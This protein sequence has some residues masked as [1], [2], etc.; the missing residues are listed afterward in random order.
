MQQLKTFLT[1]DPTSIQA[2]QIF[3]AP[4]RVAK[5]NCKYSKT[6]NDN[7]IITFDT[8]TTSLYYQGQKC[9]FVYIAMICINGH[10]Y[11]MRDLS[12]LKMFLDK[13]DSGKTL[14]VIYVHNLAFDFSF[15][16]NVIPFENVF[17][18]RAHRVI[19]ARYKSWEFRC[20]YFLSQM[21]LRNVAESYKLPSAKLVDGLDYGKIRHTQTLLT[22]TE[23][24][25]CEMD[26][27]VLYEYIRYMLKQ[28]KKYREIPYTQTGF[29]RK[30]TLE[31]LKTNGAYYRFRGR[32]KNTMPNQHVFEMLEKC[33]AGGYTH[34]N[35]MAVATG[36][37]THVR[38]YDFTS[39]YPAVMAR[40]K[41]PI[42]QFR[43]IIRNPK[44]YIDSDSYCCIGKFLLL[45]VEPRTDLAYLS[46]HKCLKTKNAVIDNGRVIRAKQII[47]CLT[48]VDIKTVKMMYDCKIIPL[49]LYAATAD[50]LPREFVLSILNLYENKTTY[51]G[52]QEQYPLYMA[53]K[54]M[55]NSEYG[56]CAFNPFT[57]GV[58]FVENEWVPVVPT[59]E[60][61]QK[62]YNNRKTVLPYAWGVFV[63][64]WAR[65][66]LCNI[67]SK[68]GNDVLYMD[69]DSIK[70][71][72]KNGQWDGLFEQDNKLIHRENL[73][74]AER[75]RIP[76][77]KFA[78]VD[79][80][81]IQHEI[82]LWDFEYEYKSFKCLGAK[83][84]CYTLYAADAIKKGDN[85]NEIYPVVAG[86]P[87]D[88][89][90]TWLK[91]HDCNALLDPFRLD[92]HLDKCDSGKSTVTY[93]PYRDITIPVR[94]YMGNV[95]PEFI[96]YG[97]HIEPATFDMSLH[98]DYLQFLCGYAVDDKQ[99]LTRN[100]VVI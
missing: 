86:C 87:T 20:S 47:I 33:F 97:A 27:I 45:D 98:D 40:C 85:P 30:Y 53:S 14:N 63:T 92:I 99:E 29:V 21:S 52:I 24:K 7:N 72:N 66:K 19:F 55:V 75:L 68:I 83:R 89:I 77:E 96:G 74:A 81:G 9:S 39:S 38:S 17:A 54:Q 65:N 62:Y 23:L 93:H 82:G 3:H 100:G 79:K 58:D 26:I 18:R 41:F 2:E 94:D 88:A 42:G 50:Y 16:I 59:W 1:L 49:E 43:R 37:H 12:E 4:G 56:M 36:R 76:F 80:H 28:Y 64:A 73:T 69:T 67:A 70:F 6:Y 90:R 8:E 10:S 11:Y 95:H 31:F 51:K 71:V 46:R 22:A 44:L 34:A 78:P 91:L 15:L 61:V 48:D 60:N 84:Y 25:Y 13:Y 32:L 57:D 5:S 35:F